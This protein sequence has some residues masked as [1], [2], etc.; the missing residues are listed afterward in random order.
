MSHTYFKYSECIW[1]H[2]QFLVSHIKKL[3]AKNGY[4]KPI[5]TSQS[6]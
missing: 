1:I 5:I 3:K 6:Q 4:K 2:Q